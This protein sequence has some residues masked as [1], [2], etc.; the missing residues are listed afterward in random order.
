MLQ[1]CKNCGIQS[2]MSVKV[3]IKCGQPIQWNQDEKESFA[4]IRIQELIS[5][6]CSREHIRSELMTRLDFS[7]RDADSF[8]D[9]ALLTEHVGNRW[10]GIV[11]FAAGFAFLAL[12][13]C[14]IPLGLMGIALLFIGLMM[15]ITGERV[16][17]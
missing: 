5:Q 3:C 11:L 15:T 2:G 10:S 8:V 14:W 7:E 1:T 13:V 12:G 17:K 6:G 9:D 16:V 4:E